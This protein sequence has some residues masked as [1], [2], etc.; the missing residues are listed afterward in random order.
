MDLC[1][2]KGI[3]IKKLEKGN[4]RNC[5]GISVRGN[6]KKENYEKRM[7]A[8]ERERDKENEVECASNY[9]LYSI[10]QFATELMTDCFIGHMNINSDHI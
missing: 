3:V 10:T 2:K 8:C 6:T 9:D 5:Y 1:I 7:R 4:G